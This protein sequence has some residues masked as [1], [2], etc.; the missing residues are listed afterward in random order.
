[1][2][3]HN[4]ATLLTWHIA[5]AQQRPRDTPI[6]KLE[7]SLKCRSCRKGHYAPPVHMIKLT[8]TLSEN[9]KN[10]WFARDRPDKMRQLMIDR[11][12]KDAEIATANR[13]LTDAFPCNDFGHGRWWRFDPTTGEITVMGDR[14]REKRGGTTYLFL[15]QDIDRDCRA[16]R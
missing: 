4:A 9:K 16:L 1:M 14:E 13:V 7:A 12:C 10:R 8:E 15:S 6:W 3:W 11:G 5:V 2:P